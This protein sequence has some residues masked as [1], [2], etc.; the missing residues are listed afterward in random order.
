MLAAQ[1]RGRRHNDVAGE[2]LTS[3][4][5]LKKHRASKAVFHWHLQF[6]SR[7]RIIGQLFSVVLKLESEGM[8]QLFFIDER[9]RKTKD[10]A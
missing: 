4:D 8:W 10:F 1:E 3:I 5:R 2:D 6:H 9:P 7:Q